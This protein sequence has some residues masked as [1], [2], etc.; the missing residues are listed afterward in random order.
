MPK[1]TLLPDHFRF[2]AR[3]E[4]F[5]L[6]CPKCG[7]MIL[8]QRKTRRHRAYVIT[9]QWNP[10]LGEMRCSGC[11]TAFG[12]GLLLYPIQYYGTMRRTIP[13]DLKPTW[14]EMHQLRQ[15]REGHLVKAGK[16]PPESANIYVET[17]CLCDPAGSHGCPLH[18]PWGGQGV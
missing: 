17:T 4:K 1:S 5:H 16:R 2:F 18:D 7:T 8:S 3:I 9:E 11:R 15:L 10:L 14:Q 12:M 6:A 13:P